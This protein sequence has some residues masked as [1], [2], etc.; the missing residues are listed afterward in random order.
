[1]DPGPLFNECVDAVFFDLHHTNPVS[2]VDLR[3]TSI[4]VW[5]QWSRWP[6]WR[7]CVRKFRSGEPPVNHRW[8]A[9]NSAAPTTRLASSAGLREPWDVIPLVR[10]RRFHNFTN[11]VGHVDVEST[12]F[13][14]QPTQHHGGVV[15]EEDSVKGDIKLVLQQVIQPNSQHGSKEFHSRYGDKLYWRDS[16]FADGESYFNWIDE[17]K[18]SNS[19]EP[20]L[21]SISKNR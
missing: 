4:D 12:R 3:V 13:W 19:S 5:K 18:I 20:P 15:P 11:S 10:R 6:C 1:M 17:A 9:V 14:V 7:I 16:G 2:R 21:W 8:L